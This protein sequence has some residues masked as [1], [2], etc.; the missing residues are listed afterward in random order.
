MEQGTYSM[1]RHLNALQI[2]HSDKYLFCCLVRDLEDITECL[3]EADQFS[4]CEDLIRVP[5]LRVFIWILGVSALLG[6]AYVVYRRLRPTSTS[7]RDITRVQDIMVGHLAVAD[8]LMG[9]YMLVIASAD[10]HYRDRY[11]F[12]AEQWQTSFV[13][14]LAGF[15]SVLS[16]EASVFFMTVISVD[17]CFGMIFPFTD[18]KLRP[19]SAKVAAVLVWIA[20]AIIS[21][22]PVTIDSYFGDAFYGRST[23]CLALP[24][25]AE[26]PPGWEYSVAIFIG[27]NLAA[28]ITMLV[29]Y[30][31]MYYVATTSSIHVGRHSESRMREIQLAMRMA[32]L[33]FSDMCCWM[34]IIV[35]GILSLTDTVTVPGITYAWTAV[36]I[37][38]LN[39]SLNPYLYTLLSRE[40]KRRKSNASMKSKRNDSLSLS[41]DGKSNGGYIPECI[42]LTKEEKF[43]NRLLKI[44]KEMAKHNILIT[45][46]VNC[47]RD[48]TSLSKLKAQH[49]L[50]KV[51]FESISRDLQTSL[52]FLRQ[53]KISC[54]YLTDDLVVVQEDNEKKINAYLIITNMTDASNDASRKPDLSRLSQL[55]DDQEKI[56]LLL[57][58]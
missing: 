27:V 7:R 21:L 52:E 37:L 51:E 23:V 42:N 24:L 17:R 36:F 3:P 9:V 46:P 12:Y 57:K 29:C 30:S 18:F 1:F 58:H 40:I 2:L 5:V 20:V 6:N 39:S 49:P 4:S 38:P 41:G 44:S 56:N 10:V 48:F 53:E 8:S 54:D 55:H 15:L 47:V 43:N 35:I 14:K 33:V 45:S 28:F 25:T 11:A 26:R 13:C 31:A 22:L 32:F 50:S 34:P 16:S 19:K